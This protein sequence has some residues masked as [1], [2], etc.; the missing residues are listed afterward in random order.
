M[1]ACFVRQHLDEPS[2][3]TKKAGHGTS[4]SLALM[5]SAE[6]LFSSLTAE[7]RTV[8]FFFDKQPFTQGITHECRTTFYPQLVLHSRSVCLHRLDT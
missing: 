3:D 5:A 8:L 4:L 6:C 7:L 2:K 1:S